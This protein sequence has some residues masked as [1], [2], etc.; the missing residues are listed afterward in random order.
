[1]TCKLVAL[2]ALLLLACAPAGAD[3]GFF[4]SIT[5]ATVESGH[6]RAVIVFEDGRETIILQTVYAGQ[7]ADFAWV[8]PTPALVRRQDV[9]TGDP[10]VFRQLHWLTE[11]RG[12]LE[13]SDGAGC[14]GPGCA[15]SG[16]DGGSDGGTVHVWDQFTV[17]GSAVSV[18]SADESA[19]LAGWLADNGYHVPQGADGVLQYYQAKSWYFVAVKLASARAL[20]GAG[21]GAPASE[22]KPLEIAF[23]TDT[24]VFPLHISSL[25]SSHTH[26]TSVMLYV[27][28]PRRVQ[29]ANYSTAEV[30][31][32]GWRG[33]DFPL[34]YDQRFRE[35]MGSPPGFVVEFVGRS[36]G[37]RPWSSYLRGMLP[38]HSDRHY[39]VTRLRT[40]MRPDGM[41]DDVEFAYTATDREFDPSVRYVADAGR[42]NVRLAGGG[43]LFLGAMFAGMRGGRP[44]RRW[45]RAAL[46]MLTL[47]LVL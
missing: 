29:V 41:T 23:D 28:A 36:N 7:E 35:A 26:E 47:V 17:G 5:S 42:R 27:I 2:P 38:I 21:G 30:N 25:S 34:F 39:Y 22:A 44:R 13:R 33:E 37:A 18:L 19:D 43:L 24:P 16:S 20:N 1:M 9:T 45:E 12:H 8:L 6:Q 15:G 14:L 32:R 10:E 4:H 40:Y 31:T 46:L 3:G 11:P